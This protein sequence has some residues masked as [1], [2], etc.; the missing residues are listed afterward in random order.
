MLVMLHHSQDQ[1]SDESFDDFLYGRNA[2]EYFK[3]VD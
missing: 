2:A 3:D 1:R